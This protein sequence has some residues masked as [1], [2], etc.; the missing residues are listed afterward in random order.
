M[1]KERRK[2]DITLECSR[3]FRTSRS[4]LSEQRIWG[5]VFSKP[6]KRDRLRPEREYSCWGWFMKL[7]NLML[8]SRVDNITFSTPINTF[9][10]DVKSSRVSNASSCSSLASL[11]FVQLDPSLCNK[12]EDFFLADS[13]ENSRDEPCNV[14]MCDTSWDLVEAMKAWLKWLLSVFSS[15]LIDL[16]MMIFCMWDASMQARKREGRKRGRKEKKERRQ[17]IW[18]Y[19]MKEGGMEERMGG[20]REGEKKG[21]GGLVNMIN[22]IFQNGERERDNMI[23]SSNKA[24]SSHVISIEIEKSLFQ[25][26]NTY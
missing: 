18:V 16:M 9:A 10:S 4:K 14:L 21:N 19:G 15:S 12:K 22:S 25:L 3:S 7:D 6:S 23:F 8:L 1:V 5:N 13:A 11:S 24:I 2:E 20:K 26:C 17:R